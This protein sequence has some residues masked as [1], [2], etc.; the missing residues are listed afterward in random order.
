[1]TA[2][3]IKSYDLDLNTKKIYQTGLKDSLVLHHPNDEMINKSSLK[4]SLDE[5]EINVENTLSLGEDEG[6]V[7]NRFFMEFGDVGLRVKDFIH[8]N[9]PFASSPKIQDWILWKYKA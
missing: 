4:K 2:T 5:R 7:H 8:A 3:V 9:K 1:M 6:G